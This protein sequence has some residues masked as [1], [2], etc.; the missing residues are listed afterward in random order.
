[1]YKMQSVDKR[2]FY[3]IKIPFFLLIAVFVVSR[4]YPL[5]SKVPIRISSIENG[6]SINEGI[7]NVSG[8]AKKATNLY[9]NGKNV[10]VTKAGEFEEPIALPAGYNIVTVEAK[11]KFGKLS[12][13]TIE[14]KII[15]EDNL[16]FS[17]KQ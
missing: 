3:Y 4:F 8:R 12:S 11:D 17:L 6:S 1:M 15:D 2:H 13:K 14:I 9:I 16:S 7:V 5:L 10:S